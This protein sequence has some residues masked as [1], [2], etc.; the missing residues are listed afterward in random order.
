MNYAALFAF[1][2]VIGSVAGIGIGCVMVGVRIGNYQALNE[3]GLNGEAHLVARTDLVNACLMVAVFL[4]F[5]YTSVGFLPVAIEGSIDP[6]RTGRVAVQAAVVTILHAREV[7]G[8]F[9]HRRLM[10]MI[11]AHE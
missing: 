9:Q 6:V 2:Q 8:F 5:L 4:G 11:R 1:I 3:G 7:Y 10:Q